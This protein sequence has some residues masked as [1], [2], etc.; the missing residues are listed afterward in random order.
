M[1]DLLM[2]PPA[3]AAAAPVK[4][5][6]AMGR[7]GFLLLGLG[8]VWVAP[9]F[10][11]PLFLLGMFAWDALVLVAWLVD[12]ARLRR[13]LHLTVQRRFQGPLALW[14]PSAVEI[15]LANRGSMAYWARV[16][17]AVPA[18]LCQ[19]PSEQTIVVPGAGES[20][21]RYSVLPQ[22]RGDVVFG[23]MHLRLQSAA[24]IAELWVEAP[25]RAPARGYP[26]LQDRESQAL[27]LTRSRMIEQQRR[28][29][30]QRGL[31]REFESLREFQEGD[32]WRDICWTATARRGKLVTRHYQTERSQSVWLVVDCGR[33]M[34]ARDG[35]LSKLDYAVN[36]ALA[37]A[38]LALHSGDRVGLLAYGRKVRTRLLPNHGAQQLRLLIEQLAQVQEETS[39]A[40]HLRTAALLM[41]MQTRRSLI[42][43]LTD[44]PETARTPDVVEAVSQL[45][46]RHLV[47]FAVIGQADL[48]SIS[49][50]PPAS[51]DVAGLYRFTAAA[52]TEHRRVVTMARLREQGV[53]PYEVEAAHLTPT[54]LNSY[55]EIKDRDRL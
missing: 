46:R 47:M 1:A 45:A 24:G 54:V 25:A 55:L 28:L 10:W 13:G 18:T 8:L 2:P 27:Y 30:Q 15:V 44:F 41:R 5:G 50:Q 6:F 14:Q 52:E 38:Q 39:E 19:E 36:T 12:L 49:S 3:T 22:R 29:A 31:G 40:D 53:L 7:R 48:R 23:S 33:L 51:Q 9:M 20:S 11:Q 17:D 32:E 16:A 37:A 26:N 4:R 42:I 21:V 43:W 35:N 34:R